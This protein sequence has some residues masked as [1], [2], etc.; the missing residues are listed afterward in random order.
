MK[1][2]IKFKGFQIPVDE[3][4][5]ITVPKVEAKVGDTLEAPVILYK[6]DGGVEFG[7]HKAVL[8]VVGHVKKPLLVFKMHRKTNYRRMYRHVQEYTKVVVEKIE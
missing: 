2:V 4:Q 1:A 7:N 5:Q 3:G 6:G 8:R